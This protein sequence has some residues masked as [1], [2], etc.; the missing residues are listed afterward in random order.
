MKP[1]PA[2]GSGKSSAPDH[3][4]VNPSN[5]GPEFKW[6]DTAHRLVVVMMDRTDGKVVQQLPPQ[7]VLD[8]VQE[9]IEHTRQ[10]LGDHSGAHR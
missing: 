9:A 6:N 10:E 3:P 7:Q 2:P 8:L 5:I 1:L 4:I